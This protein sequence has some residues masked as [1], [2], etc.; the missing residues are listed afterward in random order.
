MTE[1]LF[2][3]VV[4]VRS[5]PPKGWQPGKTFMTRTPV[6]HSEA[7]AL[8]GRL[9]K[10]PQRQ[11]MVEEV[12]PQYLEALAALRLAVHTQDSGLAS[13]AVVVL[14]QAGHTAEDCY[15]IA[16]AVSGVR[17]SYQDWTKF[18]EEEAFCG[19]QS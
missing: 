15:R 1:R 16:F 17:R 7:C 9:A 11:E 18:L 8:L 4:T 12:A 14:L 10:Y 3:V 2:H 6:P 19:L 13:S 5:P